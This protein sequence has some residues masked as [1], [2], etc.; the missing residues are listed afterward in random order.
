MIWI[1]DGQV[2]GWKGQD[3]IWGLEEWRHQLGTW[4]SGLDG[5]LSVLLAFLLE[6][7]SI[8]TGFVKGFNKAGLDIIGW[9]SWLGFCC[10]AWCRVGWR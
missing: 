1:R 4:W 6:F 8:V 9:G 7:S 3:L 2:W 10:L 5:L